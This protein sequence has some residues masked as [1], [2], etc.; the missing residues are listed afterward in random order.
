MLWF[1]CTVS[2]LLALAFYVIGME[3]G[4]Q[5]PDFSACYIWKMCLMTP[6]YFVAS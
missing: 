5:H 4:V 2:V 3:S 1:F 6:N